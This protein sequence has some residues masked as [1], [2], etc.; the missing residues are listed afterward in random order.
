MSTNERTWQEELAEALKDVGAEVASG[1]TNGDLADAWVTV[2]VGYHTAV[3]VEECSNGWE[4]VFREWGDMEHGLLEE[5]SLAEVYDRRG[6]E[7]LVRAYVEMATQAEDP[8]L[9]G[10]VHPMEWNGDH[11]AFEMRGRE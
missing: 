8:E 5:R 2:P 10:G 7:P 11:A 3:E 6:V 4:L 1:Q 9:D